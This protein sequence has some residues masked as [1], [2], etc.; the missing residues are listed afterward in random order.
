MDTSYSVTPHHSG[1]Y[2]VLT[3][4]FKAWSETYSVKAA[5]TQQYP[6][7]N[8]LQSNNLSFLLTKSI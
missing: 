8:P 7:I 5:S 4:L 3:K 1:I 2:P 6:D